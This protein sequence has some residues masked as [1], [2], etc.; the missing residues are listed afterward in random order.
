MCQQIWINT[1]VVQICR[2]VEDLVK[3]FHFE[4]CDIL[5]TCLSPNLFTCMFNEGAPFLAFVESTSNTCKQTVYPEGVCISRRAMTL[6]DSC[7]QGWWSD[8]CDRCWRDLS[9]PVALTRS[10]HLYVWASLFL[11][12]EFSLK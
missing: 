8:V 10:T 2:Y 7:L 5:F 4:Y 6:V 12:T 11:K 3:M 9:I 1:G